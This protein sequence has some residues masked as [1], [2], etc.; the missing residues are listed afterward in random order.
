MHLGGADQ[1]VVVSPN[2]EDRPDSAHMIYLYQK[3]GNLIESVAIGFVGTHAELDKLLGSLSSRANGSEI[4]SNGSFGKAFVSEGSSKLGIQD[5]VQEIYDM[6]SS[7]NTHSEYINNL[8]EELGTLS[9]EEIEQEIEKIA[10]WIADRTD[11]LR[12]Q[13]LVNELRYIANNGLDL[14]E[15]I[16]QVSMILVL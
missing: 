11:G 8:I 5:I 3:N 1:G 7:S 6:H 2:I 12:G 16:L 15:D 13:E 14:I 10:K 9:L 4:Y